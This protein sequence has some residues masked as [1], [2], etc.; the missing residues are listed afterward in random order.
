MGDWYF[1]ICPIKN[2][3]RGDMVGP[4]QVMYGH[5][6]KKNAI[7]GLFWSKMTCFCTCR[8]CPKTP[9]IRDF[10]FQKQHH[11]PLGP[12]QVELR[13]YFGQRDPIGPE[14]CLF[15]F[16]GHFWD[17]GWAQSPFPPKWPIL[18]IFIK[19]RAIWLSPESSLCVKCQ[20]DPCFFWRATSRPHRGPSKRRQWAFLIEPIWVYK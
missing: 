19:F 7:F 8:F 2:A 16:W 20:N 5:R 1:Q 12:T 14:N 13:A 4:L 10:S 6:E 3:L 11:G 9:K 17:P 18:P 15:A